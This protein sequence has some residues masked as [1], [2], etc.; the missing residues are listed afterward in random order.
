MT[1][2]MNVGKVSWESEVLK[3]SV[4]TSESLCV[5]S[6]RT[7]PRDF[8][9]TCSFA[10]MTICRHLHL[11]L[12][13]P[14]WALNLMLRGVGILK[15]SIKVLR[16]SGKDGDLRNSVSLVLKSVMGLMPHP[17]NAISRQMMKLSM[18][19]FVER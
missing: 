14:C 15:T 18:V 13:Q 2:L 12:L 1:V 17:P 5:K 10:G 9:Q 7:H 4:S 19:F 3:I 6:L 16:V 8:V 11:H